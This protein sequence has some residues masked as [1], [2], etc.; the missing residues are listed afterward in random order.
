MNETLRELRKQE[1]ELDLKIS[2]E[3]FREYVKK[4]IDYIFKRYS[5]TGWF[6]TEDDFMLYRK[7]DKNFYEIEIDGIRIFEKNIT[8]KFYW[9]RAESYI[10]YL[11]SIFKAEYNVWQRKIENN[12]KFKIDKFEE[13]K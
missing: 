7:D 6:F 11:S 12:P 13:N 8:D 4:N 1:E 3:K 10:G 9:S 5:K 2:I